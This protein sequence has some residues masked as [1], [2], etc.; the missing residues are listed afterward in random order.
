MLVYVSSESLVGP[1]DSGDAWTLSDCCG[2][3]RMAGAEAAEQLP[4]S[5]CVS[6]HMQPWGCTHS[7]RVASR[8]PVARGDA[9]AAGVAGNQEPQEYCPLLLQGPARQDDLQL[10]CPTVLLSCVYSQPVSRSSSKVSGDACWSWKG[11]FGRVF[12]SN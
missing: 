1:L 8:S 6:E 5:S 2:R 11:D 7:L 4:H 9:E 12:G 3:L 10:G